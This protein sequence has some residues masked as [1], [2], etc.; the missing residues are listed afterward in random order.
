[1]ESASKPA[2]WVSRSGPASTASD[3]VAV[4]TVGENDLVDAPVE[5]GSRDT[6]N[7]VLVRVPWDTNRTSGKHQRRIA[8]RAHDSY[9]YTEAGDIH[10]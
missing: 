7:E 6:P 10:G 3:T 2:T 5:V 9:R 8:P 4:M 1:M